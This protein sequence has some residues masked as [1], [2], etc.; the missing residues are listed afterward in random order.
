MA[1]LRSDGRQLASSDPGRAVA[2]R[3]RPALSAMALASL[4][5]LM[6]CALATP[7]AAAQGAESL[8]VTLRSVLVHGREGAPLLQPTDSRVGW[9]TQGHVRWLDPWQEATVVQE[10]LPVGHAIADLDRGED[11]LAV[12]LGVDGVGIIDLLAPEPRPLRIVDLPF[13]VDRVAVDGPAVYAA[14]PGVDRDGP[15]RLAL[16]E[17]TPGEAGAYAPSVI[18]ELE[19]PPDELVADEG[20]VVVGSG[21]GVLVR[22]RVGGGRLS[23]SEIVAA[24]PANRFLSHEVEL[25]GAVLVVGRDNGYVALDLRALPSETVLATLSPDEN[26]VLDLTWRGAYWLAS[27][28]VRQGRNVLGYRLVS[29]EG[30]GEEMREVD[31][32]DLGWP[33]Y[34][35]AW[36]QDGIAC[37]RVDLGLRCWRPD[38]EGRL[39]ASAMA[40][41]GFGRDVASAARCGAPYDLFE[42]GA[43]ATCPMGPGR[44]GFGHVDLDADGGVRLARVRPVWHQLDQLA[45]SG[46][47]AFSAAGGLFAATR[48]ADRRVLRIDPRLDDAVAQELETETGVGEPSRLLRLDDA[49]GIIRRGFDDLVLLRPDTLEQTARVSLGVGK[50][51]RATYR[52]DGR[53]LYIE[54]RWERAH[55]W[56]TLDLSDPAAP[57]WRGYDYD[58]RRP[59]RVLVDWTA[60]ADVAYGLEHDDAGAHAVAL[61][62]IS[63]R[64]ARFLG[65]LAPPAGVRDATADARAVAIGGDTLFV[66]MGQHEVARYDLADPRRPAPLDTVAV[67]GPLSGLAATGTTSVVAG[68]GDSL[69][70]LEGDAEGRDGL[71]GMW[72][73]PAGYTAG[74]TVH[75]LAGHL[76]ARGQLY[77]LD[78]AKGAIRLGEVSPA[79]RYALAGKRLID[80]KGRMLRVWDL[81]APAHPVFVDTLC[82]AREG[83]PEREPSPEDCLPDLRVDGSRVVALTPDSQLVQLRLEAGGRLREIGRLAVDGCR[84]PSGLP[85]LGEDLL[86]LAP[87]ERVRLDPTT[88]P[89]RAGTLPIAQGARA[90]AVQDGLMIVAYP[91][92][93]LV[94]DVSDPER[95][96]PMAGLRHPVEVTSL[97]LRDQSAYLHH[98]RGLGLVDLRE[99]RYPRWLGTVNLPRRADARAWQD[100]LYVT[101]ASSSA[102]GLLPRELLLHRPLTVATRSEQTYLP[103][104]GRR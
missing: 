71:P 38:E 29:Y 24:R 28:Q 55:R 45:G 70:V 87:P 91:G 66:A 73:P 6:A 88:G 65:M 99:P 52:H 80:L 43:V 58:L 13:A 72:R 97:Q 76:V 98:P 79:D 49:L 47:Y 90:L 42:G 35:Q 4:L 2:R 15:H 85:L 39:V 23:D 75:L 22:R 12:A 7:R 68:T 10:E 14:G 61:H 50:P 62:D 96:Q 77:R 81:G 5:A 64:P 41:G 53:S 27:E 18:V 31:A 21:S 34:E 40:Y 100:R 84:P 59:D 69:I 63:R 46:R 103:W 33:E 30:S 44:I 78:P 26:K 9:A 86:F 82:L 20:R 74:R 36:A 104:L 101:V 1:W 48:G 57:R 102:T 60:R 95:P 51:E 92:S 11:L 67:P 3:M 94:V 32:L 89:R 56:L 93:L 25:R 19:E 17:P 83:C 54:E 8:T 37:L 16:I